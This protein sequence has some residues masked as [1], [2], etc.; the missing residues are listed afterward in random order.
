MVELEILF[1][2]VTGAEKEKHLYSYTWLIYSAQENVIYV[3]INTRESE[4]SLS[5]ISNN[6]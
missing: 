6:L 5:R 3:Q 1:R 2:G 4:R